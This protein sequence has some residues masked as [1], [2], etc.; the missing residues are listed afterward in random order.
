MHA[1]L[2]MR[3]VHHYTLTLNVVC[4]CVRVCVCVC[5]CVCACTRSTHRNL[6]RQQQLSHDARHGTS[7]AP[8]QPRVVHEQ[9]VYH[10]RRR[11]AHARCCAVRSPS[12]SVSSSAITHRHTRPWCPR[13]AAC[14]RAAGARARG[15]APHSPASRPGAAR[16]RLG[17]LQRQERP[18]AGCQQRSFTL[19]PSPG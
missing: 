6:P 7:R 12:S 9:H 5:V 16:E 11:R 1:L 8:R 2:E 17:E 19:P 4:A 3:N 18:R 15:A 14:R 13:A 10:G